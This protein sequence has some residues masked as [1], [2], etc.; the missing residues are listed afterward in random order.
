MWWF[1]LHEI[2]ATFIPIVTLLSLKERIAISDGIY[3][4]QEK[5]MHINSTGNVFVHGPARL[6]RPETRTEK[7]ICDPT[8]YEA[9]KN[10]LHWLIVYKWNSTTSLVWHM[11]NIQTFVLFFV[12][13]WRK[14]FFLWT[15]SIKMGTDRM[16]Q[17]ASMRKGR[18]AKHVAWVFP[19]T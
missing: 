1:E 12:I 9:G 18:K 15:Q 19:K 7:I 10:V 3:I 16:I 14:I 6:A 5:K 17:F 11:Q 4:V 13:L 8:F 2:T